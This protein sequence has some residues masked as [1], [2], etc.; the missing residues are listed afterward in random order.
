MSSTPLNVAPQEIVHQFIMMMI[1]DAEATRQMMA[2]EAM[3]QVLRDATQKTNND[4]IGQKVNTDAVRLQANARVNWVGQQ[5]QE[6]YVD[7]SFAQ[8]PTEINVHAAQKVVSFL[9]KLK[10]E[11][12]QQRSS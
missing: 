9:T 3:A 7:H 10:N 11:R 12:T 8:V 6:R 1:N 2:R 5:L 4:Q